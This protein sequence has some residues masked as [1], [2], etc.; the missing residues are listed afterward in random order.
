[1]GPMEERQGHEDEAVE[2]SQGM[3]HEAVED[4]VA[5]RLEPSQ[6]EGRASQKE[7]DGKEERGGRPPALNRSDKRGVIRPTI[8]PRSST[9]AT[10][11]ERTSQAA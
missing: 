5:G 6:G 4:L 1:M 3:R 7:M 8:Y 11:P 2:S 9:K 10:A